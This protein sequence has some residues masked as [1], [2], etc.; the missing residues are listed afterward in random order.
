[1]NQIITPVNAAAAI[2]ANMQTPYE[3]SIDKKIFNFEKT[4]YAEPSLFFGQASGL[5]DTINQHYPQLKRLYSRLKVLDWGETEFPFSQCNLEFKRMKPEV[6]RPMIV[7]LGWQWETDSIAARSITPI[8]SNFLTND[9]AFRLYQR[10]GDNECLVEGT[11]VLTPNGWV[12]LSEVTTETLVTQFDPET[13]TTSFVKPSRVIEKDYKGPVLEFKNHQKHFH[14]VVTPNHRML[15]YS[16]L[17]DTYKVAT[18]DSLDYRAGSAGTLTSAFSAGVKTTGSKSSLTALERLLIAVQADGSVSDRYD[19]SIVGTIPVRFAF[20]KDRKVERI[21]ELALQ[22]GFNLREVAGSP[23]YG[24]RSSQRNFYLDVPA[25]YRDFL[26]NY[27]WVNLEEVTF[28]WCRDFLNEQVHWDGHFTKNTGILHTTSREAVEVSQACAAL[29]GYKTHLN[30]VPDNRKESFSGC[31][32]LSWKDTSLVSGQTINKF[33]YDYEGKVRCLTVPTGF[34]LVRYE[35][36][37]SVTGN[38]THA[39]TYAEIVRF[40][41]DNPTEVMDS[42]LGISESAQRL[43]TVS[44]VF[45]EAYKAGLELSLGIRKRDQE[46]FNIFFMFVV[47]LFMMERLQF[48]ISFGIT[49]TYAQHSHFLPI[50]KAVQKICQ[51]EYEIHAL[52]GAH[53]YNILMDTGEGITANWACRDTIVKMFNEIMAVEQKW[54]PFLLAG[55]EDLFGVTLRDYQQWGYFCAGDVASVL[56]IKTDFTVPKTVPIDFLK[57]WIN[58]SSI[59]ASLQ[60]EK[61]A[62]YMIGAVIRDDIGK[63]FDVTGL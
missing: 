26:K 59:Q 14:Q 62:A 15:S 45:A 9:T 31:W 12:D 21:T 35:G 25:E 38:C 40:S 39:A 1:M 63:V 11:E 29:A 52:A 18:A 42:V 41:F 3:T 8:M 56:G 37:V 44:K 46:T 47:A 54:L 43:E 7:Q 48:M 16:K 49:F 32:R 2:M 23:A 20:A 61:S 57:N 10:I 58:I 51:D 36:S 17:D 22:A 34:F 50:G 24:N 13:K 28:E 60:E 19:G 53:V 5:F 30:Y 27:T 55:N 6:A 33:E 4:D